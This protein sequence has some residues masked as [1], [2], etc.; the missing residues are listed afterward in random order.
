MITE[1]LDKY[2]ENQQREYLRRLLAYC[3]GNV[4]RAA[5]IA[6]RH[7]THFYALLKRLGL[8]TETSRYN[9]RC[10]RPTAEWPFPQAVSETIEKIKA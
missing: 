10:Y 3:D 9:Y 5:Q 6:G 7:R 4:T 8:G 1:T 2:I